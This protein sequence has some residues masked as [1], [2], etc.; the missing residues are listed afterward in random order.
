MAE[1]GY[2]DL[3]DLKKELS[4]RKEDSVNSTELYAA[5]K[6][7]SV[8]IEQLTE[9]FRLAIGQMTNEDDIMKKVSEQLEQ[10]LKNDQ[11]LAR[12]LLLV[13]EIEKDRKDLNIDRP[14][15]LRRALSRRRMMR[16]QRMQQV[17]LNMPDST[18]PDDLEV[19]FPDNASGQN[20]V[21]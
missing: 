11:D 14:L 18:E 21:Q 8:Q 5:V 20:K 17:P 15:P 10:L 2:E 9:I 19:E 7:L 12:G 16:S 13:L 1:D 4:G 6:A 3:D